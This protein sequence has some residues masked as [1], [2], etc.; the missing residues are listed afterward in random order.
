MNPNLPRPVLHKFAAAVT[1]ALIAC[2]PAH[3]QQAYE[4]VDLKASDLAPPTLLKGPTHTVDEK[5]TFENFMPRFTIRSTYGV[6]E[7]RGREMLDIRVSELSA[8]GQ[9]NDVSKTDA[10]TSALGKA[11]AQPVKVAGE[12][13]QNPVDTTG[14]VVSGVGVMFGR[15]GRFVGSTASSA[16]DKIGGPDSAPPRAPIAATTAAPEQGTAQPRTFL[17]DP[18]GYNKARRDWAQKLKVDPYTS[19]G[20][21]SDKLGD[22]AKVTFAGTFSVGVGLGAVA[23]P[24]HYTTEAYSQGT[25]EA[26]QSPPIDVYKRNEE[27]LNSMGV[28]SA[29]VR[30]LT[31]SGHF[32]PTLE[33]TLVLALQSLGRVEGR[34]DVVTFATRAIS[35]LEARYINNSVLLLAKYGRTTPLSRVR[36][37]DRFIAGETRDGKLVIALPL[38]VIAWTEVV[39]TFATRS[40]LR[41]KERRLLV[42]G[43][44]TPVAKQQLSALGWDVQDK[45]VAAN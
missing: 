34:G 27:R 5:V 39:N 30:A 38:D 28:D 7:A 41:G 45:L 42:A 19:N 15:A 43:T 18:L 26:Y 14:N 16:G 17:G 35:E 6:W 21:L 8:F 2:G 44:V 10:F 29:R 31:R 40:D 22:V 23:A 3:A 37:F 33:T 24:L 32:T 11:V 9:L 36:A 12:F 20:P 1:L 4:Q 13:V 25:L